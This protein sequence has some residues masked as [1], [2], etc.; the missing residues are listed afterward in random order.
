M[1]AITLLKIFM[2]TTFKNCIIDRSLE[3]KTI[4]LIYVQDFKIFAEIEMSNDTCMFM[5]GLDR[6]PLN[7]LNCIRLIVRPRIFMKMSDTF[8]SKLSDQCQLVL[9]LTLKNSENP[10]L[11]DEIMTSE[12]NLEM[13]N[14]KLVRDSMFPSDSVF[15][16]ENFL[17]YLL[18]SST[19]KCTTQKRSARKRIVR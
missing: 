3:I 4:R 5:I 6:P 7:H 1:K 16:R 10:Q 13:N 15:Y 19:R 9:T 8:I 18:F 2:A 11:P 14:Q 17:E 12:L